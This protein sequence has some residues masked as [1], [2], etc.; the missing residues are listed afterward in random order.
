MKKTKLCAFFVWVVNSRGNTS[1]KSELLF[2]VQ[3]KQARQ[4]SMG[5]LY[6]FLINQREMGNSDTLS[7]LSPQVSHGLSLRICSLLGRQDLN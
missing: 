6:L 4:V 3:N 1:T 2:S 5:Q 7:G